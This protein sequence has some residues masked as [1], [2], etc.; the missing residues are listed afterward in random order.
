MSPSSRG[1]S[2]P[3]AVRSAFELHLHLAL[4]GSSP[5][6]FAPDTTRSAIVRLHVLR[7]GPTVLLTWLET[8]LGAPVAPVGRV[9]RTFRY[10]ERL[11]RADLTH[12]RQSFALDPLA[13]AAVLL[14]RRDELALAGWSG[15][16]ASEGDG[17]V[18]D[19]G[20]VE[21]LEPDLP[22]GLSERIDR[23]LD[24]LDEGTRLPPHRVV[25]HDP[26]D[27]WPPRWR[28]L[29]RRLELVSADAPAPTAPE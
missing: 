14:R 26:I 13:T 4:A 12:T 3:T 16:N 19:L 1:P 24:R 29:L 7:G 8:Q 6:T 23:V 18:E 10:L 2:S 22:L 27:A 15:S 5:P 9:E 17:L 28:P 21:T 20:R 25:L 11:E